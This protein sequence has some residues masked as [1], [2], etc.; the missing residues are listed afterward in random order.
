MYDPS[1]RVLT[2]LELLQEHEE[3]TGQELAR[4][5]EV[6]ARTVQR[7]VARLQDLGVPV[8]GRRGV[9]GAYR[10]RP[11][12]RLPPL[13]FTAQEATSVAL[14]LQ[15]LHLL[16]L[17]SLT[18]ATTGARSKLRRALPAALRE[19]VQ[20]LEQAVQFGQGDGVRTDAALLAALTVAVQ[21]GRTV[22]FRYPPT[23]P[24]REARGPQTRRVN[25]YRALH[26]WGRWYAVGQCH[27]RGALRSF[28]LDRMT[29]LQI[30]PERFVP[31]PD[32]D[33]LGVL[34]AMPDPVHTVE[35][36]LDAPPHALR[37][38]LHTWG[39]ALEPDGTGT[40]LHCQRDDLHSFAAHL[41]TLGC[42]FRVHRPA[43]LLDALQDHQRRCATALG[44][45]NGPGVTA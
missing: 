6:S 35:V 41:L 16:G 10:L 27:L 17:D 5:L 8:E 24:D 21:Q 4:H 15:A 23:G 43:A 37:A 44:A 33:A 26:H 9:G 29:D 39:A 18:P 11:G 14:G 19:Q 36:W 45:R 20:A 31:P 32:F 25:V 34:L 42:D 30:C 13:M 22:T 38:R 3:I 1:M 12:Y 7:Y 2:V 40:R 28:R